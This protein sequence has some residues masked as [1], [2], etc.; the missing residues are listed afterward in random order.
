MAKSFGRESWREA[1]VFIVTPLSYR[2][3]TYQYS[4]PLSS[5]RQDTRAPPP[6]PLE[7]PHANLMAAI[8]QA[9]GAGKAKLRSAANEPG[10]KDDKKPASGGDLM[11]DLHAKL[12]M[13][14][15]GISGAERGGG[16]VLHT[17]ASVIPEPDHSSPQHSSTD[18]DWE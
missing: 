6:P 5:N 10:D 3:H 9:G 4:K 2:R 15:R 8:R 14:R 1:R 17:L 13:R 18:D 12:S 11:A 7:N 16:S